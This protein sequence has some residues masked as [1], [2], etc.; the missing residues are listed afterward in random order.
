[1]ISL[2][3]V[4]SPIAGK[5]TSRLSTHVVICACTSCC[6][7][8]V[9][10]LYRNRAFKLLLWIFQSIE[11]IYE[12]S[13]LVQTVVMLARCTLIEVYHIYLAGDWLYSH[14][15]RS[16]LAPITHKPV[17]QAFIYQHGAHVHAPH[18]PVAQAN[19]FNTVYVVMLVERRIC[20]QFNTFRKANLDSM[21][22][23]FHN[24]F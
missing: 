13:L 23:S 14:V 15:R 22:E 4:C 8:R 19:M 1:M 7:Y 18:K 24:V 5:K 11:K 6:T 16:L 20:S 2:N 10:C 12:Q 9:K 3:Y 21:K 17:A